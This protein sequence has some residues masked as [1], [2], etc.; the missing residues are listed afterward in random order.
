MGTTRDDFSKA[1]GDNV[2]QGSESTDENGNV[3]KT[4]SRAVRYFE[5]DGSDTEFLGTK[6][7]SEQKSRRTH[8]SNYYI[9]DFMF[10]NKDGN[11]ATMRVNLYE[12]AFGGM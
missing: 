8:K 11:I 10:S 6:L 3:E 4:A 1:Y 9:Q 12:A 2:N 5:K 7:T